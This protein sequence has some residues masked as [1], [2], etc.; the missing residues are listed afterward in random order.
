MAASRWDAPPE[1]KTVRPS[2]PES[3]GALFRE[4][5]PERFLLDLRDPA[6]RQALKPNR[7][8]RAI[9]VL[10]LPETERVSHYFDASLA[11]QFDAFV[12]LEETRSVMPVTEAVARLPDDH[13]FA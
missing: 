4:A 6:L 1:V 3:D 7:P 9:G 8:Q 13:P 2:L 10:Y 5:G 11:D 12:F